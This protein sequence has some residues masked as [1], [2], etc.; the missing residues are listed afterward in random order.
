MSPAGGGSGGGERGGSAARELAGGCIAGAANV[1]SGYP[2]DTIKVKLQASKG[3]Y[4]GMNDCARHI[5]RTEG[6]SLRLFFLLV[7]VRWGARLVL[8]SRHAA[9]SLSL[10]DRFLCATPYHNARQK[11]KDARLFPRPQRAAARRRRRDG[12]QLRGVL[13]RAA[14]ADGRSS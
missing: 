14:R 2:F 12:R 5:W 7:C 9:L 6:V 13:E 8:L 10:S 11:Q 1:T 4:A 3:M